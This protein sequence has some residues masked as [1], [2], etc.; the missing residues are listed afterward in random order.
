M[1]VVVNSIC[2]ACIESERRAI[3]QLTE[4][5]QG[6]SMLDILKQTGAIGSIAQQLGV[7]EQMAEMGAGAL[8]PAILGGFKKTATAQPA[9]LE[10]LGGL[11]GQ[12]GGG[13]LFDSVV[14]PEPTPVEQGN[15]VLGQIF[16]S[17]DVSRSVADHASG[18]TGIDPSLLKKMLPILA[19][20]V[21]GY[22][23]KQAGGGEQGGGLGGLIGGMLGGGGGESGG[24]GIGGMLGNVLGGALGGGQQAAPAGGG[25]LGGL[26]S[27]LDMD[28]DG[29]PLDDIIGMAGK[30]AR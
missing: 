29:N 26:G 2:R 21:A 30:L 17:K 4:G 1:G 14:A 16:G 9:G 18:Q 19:M 22:M 25:G 7:N 10:G 28:G 27:L 3:C 8:L 23:A 12:L 11:L 15:D 6:M 13:G 24:G 5:D 20:L